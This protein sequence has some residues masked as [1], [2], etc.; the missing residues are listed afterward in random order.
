ML[1]LMGELG[2]PTEKHHHEVVGACQHGLDEI[3]SL[4]N[5]AD[6]V[7]TYRMLSEMLQIW[8]NSNI[9][10]QTWCRG[11]SQTA[12][13]YIGGILKHALILAFTNPTTNSYKRLVQESEAL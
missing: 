9:Y 8:K 12:R 7:M 2:I 1:L 4:I 11:L 5:S 3:D 13:W 6:N 10:A